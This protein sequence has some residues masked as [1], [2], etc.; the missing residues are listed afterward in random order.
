MV[1]NNKGQV[2]MYTLMLGITIIVLGLALA[3]PTKDIIN[4]VMSDLTCSDP[5]D[6]YIQG[7]CW[8][9]DFQK[10]LLIGGI[11]FAGIAIVAARNYFSP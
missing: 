11:I 8:Y 7:A 5:Y 2:W 6:N 4:Q 9:M 3:G 10:P 1:L